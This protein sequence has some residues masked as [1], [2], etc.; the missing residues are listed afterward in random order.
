MQTIYSKFVDL[1]IFARMFRGGRQLGAL[2]PSNLGQALKCLAQYPKNMDEL[3][4]VINLNRHGK[5]QPRK[6]P[7][8][9]P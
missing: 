6:M 5:L 8:R 3:L 2:I 7:M 9:F 4:V 1:C